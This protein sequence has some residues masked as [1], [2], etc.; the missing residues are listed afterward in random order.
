MTLKKILKYTNE[1]FFCRFNVEFHSKIL[2]RI[3][4]KIMERNHDTPYFLQISSKYREFASNLL[5]ILA[6]ETKNLQQCT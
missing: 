1:T 5:G 6:L 2:D 3:P 4:R